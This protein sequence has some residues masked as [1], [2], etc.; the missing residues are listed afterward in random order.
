M[1]TTII[2]NHEDIDS[3]LKK[4]SS[5]DYKDG[6]LNTTLLSEEIK[7]NIRSEH[8]TEL[9]IHFNNTKLNIDFE[10]SLWYNSSN[11]QIY[12]IKVSQMT[13]ILQKIPRLPYSHESIIN[14]YINHQ[15]H[16]KDYLPNHHMRYD[17][18]M[19][20]FT[21]NITNQKEFD[22]QMIIIKEITKYFGWYKW[23]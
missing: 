2:I 14:N 9:F 11:W 21:K 10:L 17:V 15:Y 19:I 3:L 8:K 13:T 22:N 20:E 16:I 23:Y 6:T 1:N 7:Y 4:I 5:T 12:K 18:N